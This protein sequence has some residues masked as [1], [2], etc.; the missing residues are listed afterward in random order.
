AVINGG[1][2]AEGL[3]TGGNLLGVTR[4]PQGTQLVTGAPLGETA[5]ILPGMVGMPSLSGCNVSVIGPIGP[6]ALSLIG[7]SN[8][9][10]SLPVGGVAQ[11]SFQRVTKKVVHLK[12]VHKRVLR[13]CSHKRIIRR[14][15]LK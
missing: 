11:R 1:V 12:K 13:K 5:I 3:M 14:E 15:I 6:S 4:L 2:T 7:T 10:A 8:F 9:V